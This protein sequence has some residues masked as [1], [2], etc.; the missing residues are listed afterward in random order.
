MSSSSQTF[1]GH[2]ASVIGPC[3]SIRIAETAHSG[4]AIIGG[5]LYSVAQVGS[6][7]RIPLGYQ[8]LYG[9]VSEVGASAAPSH[10]EDPMNANWIQVQLV[11]ESL[12]TAFERGISQ[13]PNIN[14][15]VHIVTEGDLQKIYG[16][17]EPGQIAIGRLA[18]AESITVRID[19]DK[20]VTR[21]SAVLGSTG[22]GKSTTV[23]SLL[24]S[25]ANPSNEEPNP[26]ARIVLIDIH[27]E[28][29]S[30]LSDCATVFRINPN[31]GENELFAPFWA[32]SHLNLM[33]F[34]TGGVDK[35]KVLHFLDKIVELKLL[36]LEPNPLPGVD[37]SSLTVDTPIP[38]SL[39]RLWYEMINVEL[40]TF[41]G[42]ERNRP[43][44]VEKGDSESLKP[45]TYKPHAMGAKGPFL[46]TMAPGL[47]R[48]LR[49][50]R[51]RLLDHQYDFLLHPGSYEPD[52][53]G[54]TEK[55]L[56]D[57]LRSWLGHEKPVTILDLSGVPSIILT[58]LVGSILRVIYE[59]L[60]WSREKSEGAI[61]RPLLV[62]M[63]EAHRY[64]GSG[65]SN[66]ASELAQRIFKEGRKHGIGAMVV[67]QRPSEV[68]DT[69]LSQCGT[70]VTLR[71]SNPADRSSIQGTLPDNLA[72]LLDMLPVLRTGEAIV[73]GE[74]AKLPFRCRI[75]LPEEQHRPNSS[76]PEVARQWSLPRRDESYE[77]VV[78]SWRAQS[79]RATIKD[80][81]IERKPVGGE[82]S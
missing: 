68:D 5:S 25:I 27:G 17:R 15:D 29:A 18:S 28:Y 11:G 74:A 65:E 62:V 66:P 20:L 24:R 71:M 52:Y 60:Y 44:L 82:S 50:L 77:R 81:K 61:T 32:L 72:S 46:N 23:A 19:L 42:P 55:G 43:A 38:Y 21:H 39:K 8:D 58:R 1:L 47:R 80:L 16:A 2:V 73:T 37:K 3:V 35:D 57:L 6:F 41:E 75:E 34:L 49:N 36:S 33:Q 4:T 48:Q 40:T 45:P 10:T 67:S 59:A 78:A 64:L 51:S 12:G 76:D 22:S 14:D 70:F 56:P 54:N 30:A 13:Y 7:V 63:E 26:S 9:I 69:I 79:P 53:N 31:K